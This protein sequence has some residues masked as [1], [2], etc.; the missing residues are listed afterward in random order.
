[1]Y[2]L[3]SRQ[4][5]IDAVIALKTE[6]RV[7]WKDA[8]IDTLDDLPSAQPERKKGKWLPDCEYD[9]E[10]EWYF[11]TCSCCEYQSDDKFKYCPNCGAEMEKS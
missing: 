4:A 7:S 1:M 3:I 6:H 10:D 11:Y 5:A 9:G 8:V 2:D